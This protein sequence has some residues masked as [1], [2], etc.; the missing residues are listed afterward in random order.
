LRKLS[1][2][3]VL[4]EGIDAS[5]AKKPARGRKCA[6]PPTPLAHAL[7][8]IGLPVATS[9]AAVGVGGSHGQYRSGRASLFSVFGHGTSYSAARLGLPLTLG[10][11]RRCRVFLLIFQWGGGER[12]E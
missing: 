4:Q 3:V 10:L 12:K 7:T 5:P 1:V 8:R 2:L 9:I 6:A 11:S